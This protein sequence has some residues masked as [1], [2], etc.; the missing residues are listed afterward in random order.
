MYCQR[1]HS[2]VVSKDQRRIDGKLLCVAC[3]DV[4]GQDRHLSVVIYDQSSPPS[5]LY[6]RPIPCGQCDREWL[7]GSYSVPSLGGNGKFY[8]SGEILTDVPTESLVRARVVG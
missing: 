2:E 1:C 8:H 3:F 4:Y 7:R 5:Q 6:R